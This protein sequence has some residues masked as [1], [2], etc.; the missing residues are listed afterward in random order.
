MIEFY[1]FSLFR[2]F[3]NFN[4]LDFFFFQKRKVSENVILY[5]YI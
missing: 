5:I 1:I 2:Y 3:L 4:Y